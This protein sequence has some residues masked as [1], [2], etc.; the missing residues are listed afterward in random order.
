MPNDDT[1]ARRTRAASARPRPRLLQQRQPAALPLD[2]R[3]R[4]LR[5]QRLRQRSCCSASTIF[6]TPSTPAAACVCPRFDFDEPSHSGRSAR[7]VGPN[8]AASAPASIGSPRLVP[9]P[10]ASTAS[11]SSGLTPARRQR[12]PDHALLRADRWAPSAP[13]CG[14]PGS[15]QSRG[16]TP[17]RD[18]RR[19]RASDRR[20]STSMPQPSA[21]PAPSA[22]AEKLLQRPSGAMPA[23]AG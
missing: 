17:A 20:F 4:L 9:V 8:T 6:I 13:G 10:C 12:R 18:R 15:P 3:A 19:A 2:V 14:R 21:Q 5:V 1:P 23:A 7:R 22:P 11:M 16:S